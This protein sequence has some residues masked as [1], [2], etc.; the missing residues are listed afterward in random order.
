MPDIATVDARALFT[1]DLVDVYSDMKEAPKYFGSY[2]PESIHPTKNLSIEVVRNSE[3]IAVDV[4]RGTEGNLNTFSKSTEKIFTPPLFDEFFNLTE[5]DLYDALYTYQSISGAMYGRLV[6]D[7][8]EKVKAL[9]NKIDRSYELMRAQALLTGV[10]TLVNGDN[11][12]FGRK[13]ASLVDLAATA[14]GYWSAAVDPFAQI[15]TMINFLRTQGKATGHV[16]DL[17]LGDSAIAALYANAAFKARQN[18]FS[19]RLDSVVPPQV[20]TEGSV[21]HGEITAGPYRV[22]LWSYPE[23]YTNASGVMVP[24]MTPEYGILLPEKPHF[25]MAYAAVPQLVDPQAGPYVGKYKMYEFT[26]QR[27]AIHSIGLKSAGVPITT[28]ID[29]VVTFKAV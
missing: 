16:Y 24:Y 18:L 6:L 25:K 4:L 8:A 5:L 14:G 11:I 17:T 28:A 20:S 15:Q 12:N 1:V 21:Y 9:Q 27:K 22:R 23:S 3:K 29:Q 2:F 10:V 13:A 7:V 26:D 19:M